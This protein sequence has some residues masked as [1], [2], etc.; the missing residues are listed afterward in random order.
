MKNNIL[1][2][3]RF[4][5]AL[6]VA[7]LSVLAFSGVFYKVKIFDF[8]FTAALENGMISGFGFGLIIFIF[9]VLITLLFGRVYCSVLCP[10]GIY[11]EILMFLFAPFYKKR[12]NIAQKHY[13]FSYFLAAILFGTLCGG[14]VFLVRFIDPYSV[15]SRALSMSAFGLGFL[16]CLTVLVFFK[17][18]FFCLNICPV[19]AVLGV[20]SRFS[21]FKMHIDTNLCKMC[22]LCAKSCPMGSIDFKN[23][24][25]DNETCIKCFKCLS[26]CPHGALYYGLPKVHQVRFNATRRQFLK[27]SLVLATFSAGILSGIKLCRLIGAKVKKVILP[28]GAGRVEDFANRCFN[29][30][31]CVENCPMKIIQK[32]TL[33]TPFVHIQYGQKY[34]DFNCHQC[35]AVC[36]TGALKRLNLKEKQQ[37]QIGVAHVDE[38]TCIQCGLCVGECPREIIVKE[39]GE[40]PVILADK[41]IGC[42][43]CA[44]VC[45][46]KAIDVFPVDEQ[47]LL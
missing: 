31:L 27:S 36:P 11:Q 40:F 12:K 38:N 37:M 26:D 45:P 9:L 35:S 34:C 42:H 33:E 20:I 30:N 18:R 10:L 16:L 47:N 17:K 8:Q 44:S 32:A 2:Y 19:G 3:G 24:T 23:K 25:I 46:V 39:F 22:G 13:V 29:C 4:L 28:A 21:L 5:A 15:F 14:T 43:K 7:V 6:I 1:K 41:C